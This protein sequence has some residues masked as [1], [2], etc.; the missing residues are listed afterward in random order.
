MDSDTFGTQVYY[1]KL[2]LVKSFFAP[3]LF[4]ADVN[5]GAPDSDAFDYRSDK[6]TTWDVLNT[7]HVK[8]ES[9]NIFGLPLKKSLF[10]RLLFLCGLIDANPL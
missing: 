10:Y 7:F 2:K 8:H 3:H 1:T 6:I 9:T 5:I 4:S